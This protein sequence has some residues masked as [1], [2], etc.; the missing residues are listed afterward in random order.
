MRQRISPLLLLVLLAAAVGGAG[1]P[2]GVA[3][4]PVWAAG[5]HKPFVL[6]HGPSP[7][8]HGAFSLWLAGRNF[9]RDERVHVSYRLSATRG[10]GRSAQ[11]VALT[12]VRGEFATKWIHFHVA[13]NAVTYTLKIT[14]RGAR[15]EHLK[16]TTTGAVRSK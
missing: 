12:N 7:A 13:R 1:Y 4:M 6:V 10:P 15:G 9:G 3:T 14:V 5:L 2:L 11:Q 16:I 8:V